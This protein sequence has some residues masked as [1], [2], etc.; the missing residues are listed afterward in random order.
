MLIPRYIR[1]MFLSVISSAKDELIDPIEFETRAAGDYAKR[2][3]AQVYRE[4]QQVLRQ[5]N[6]LDFDDLIMKTVELF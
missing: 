2:I 3:Q 1:K 5:N 6:A 4:Y